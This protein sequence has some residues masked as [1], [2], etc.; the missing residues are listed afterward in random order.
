MSKKIG[1]LIGIDYI[2]QPNMQLGGCINDVKLIEKMLREQLGFEEIE[3]LTDNTT[4]KPTYDN[5]I[6]SILKLVKKIKEGLYNE[7]WFHYSGHGYFKKD[8]NND[9]LDG[10]DEI[11]IPLDFIYTRKYILDDYLHNIFTSQLPDTCMCVSVFD[12]CHSG[13]MLDLKYRYIFN[14][15]DE[16]DIIIENKL[17]TNNNIMC[18]SG[19]ADDETSSELYIY[20]V[21]CPDTQS[22]SKNVYGVTTL[23]LYYTLHANSYDITCFSMLNQMRDLIKKWGLK[24]KCQ[25]TSSFIL[26]PNQYFIQKKLVQNGFIKW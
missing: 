6:N 22:I 13:T 19:C 8:Y 4:I 17:N 11:L 15:N 2:N 3:I 24:Q 18:I 9:E 14:N 23:A 21:E 20:R 26:P 5:I 25:L 12:C 7:V 10:Y 16:S 1:L